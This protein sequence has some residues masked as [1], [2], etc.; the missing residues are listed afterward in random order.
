MNENSSKERPK[1][2]VVGRVSLKELVYGGKKL[3][4]IGGIKWLVGQSFV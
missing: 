3:Y 2:S 1:Q 4:A